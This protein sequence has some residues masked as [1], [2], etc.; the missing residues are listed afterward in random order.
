MSKAKERPFAMPKRGQINPFFHSRNTPYAGTDNI[1]EGDG[2]AGI[3]L[4]EEALVTQH[5]PR[6][7]MSQRTAT[8]VLRAI[9]WLTERAGLKREEMVLWDYRCALRDLAR[10]KNNYEVRI[11]RLDVAH[12]KERLRRARYDVLTEMRKLRA[13]RATI[14]A[15][16]ARPRALSCTVLAES[17][18]EGGVR[19]VY[20][21][22]LVSSDAPEIVEYVGQ[23]YSPHSR[24][25]GHRKSGMPGVQSLFWKAHSRGASVQMILIEETT[26]E[27]ADRRE[28][29]FISTYHAAGM[30]RLNT[31]GVYEWN[32]PNIIGRAA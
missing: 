15:E 19:K 4:I 11:R 17:H 20:I 1:L 25:E 8:H 16:R 29:H 3:A 14:R 30:A 13:V 18:K 31:A 9:S 24:L 32:D 6:A 7:S 26:R 22:G 2:W 27:N 10:E 5:G 12:L 23:T 28:S 21:Y